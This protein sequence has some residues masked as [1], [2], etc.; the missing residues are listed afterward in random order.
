MAKSASTKLKTR[1]ILSIVLF[2]LTITIGTSGYYLIEN[3]DIFDSFYM[4]VITL[5][6]VGYQE[7]QPLS[8]A[9]KLFTVF[10]IFSGL[11]IVAFIMNYGLRAFPGDHFSV[12]HYIGIILWSLMIPL[13]W[14]LIGCISH[15]K[16][17]LRYYKRSKL[18]SRLK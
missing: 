2:F 11:S 4:T 17:T 9:G 12:S 6:T 10:L 18:Y 14:T 8:K 15:A 13:T 3:W 7:V 1:I 5:S 16:F